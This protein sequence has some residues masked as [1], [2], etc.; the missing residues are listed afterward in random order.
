MPALTGHSITPEG[1]GSYVFL[2]YDNR[3]EHAILMLGKN[4]ESLHELLRA[5]GLFVE[6]WRNSY[7]SVNGTPN[8]YHLGYKSKVWGFEAP[9]TIILEPLTIPI[10]ANANTL[11]ALN[12]L[13]PGLRAIGE[14][15]NTTTPNKFHFKIV[16]A[17]TGSLNWDPI[18]GYA[19]VANPINVEPFI[20]QYVAEFALQTRTLTIRYVPRD[21]SKNFP[22]TTG[23]L[24][25][26]ITT[27]TINSVGNTDLTFLHFDVEFPKG[28]TAFDVAD[29][30]ASFAVD[31]IS[32]P[33]FINQVPSPGTL[34]SIAPL[35]GN[36]SSNSLPDLSTYPP[37]TF[38][39]PWPSTNFVAPSKKSQP[40]IVGM[41]K[42]RGT[43]KGAF[44]GRVTID[45]VWPD[46]SHPFIKKIPKNDG[47]PG[48][49]VSEPVPPL[50]A[51]LTATAYTSGGVTLVG[52]FTVSG[53][54]VLGFLPGTTTQSPVSGYEVSEALLK[55][56]SPPNTNRMYALDQLQMAMD[57][58]ETLKEEAPEI[59]PILEATR[60]LK[61]KL[62]NVKR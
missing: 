60:A 33:N 32:N 29:A 34:F 36:L 58:F 6:A 9:I 48:S 42:E 56:Y 50:C 59:L 17:L 61:A 62:D 23:R 54:Q 41:G 11:I 2:D 16:N 27:I 47:V 55:A 18:P 1:L 52:P 7:N 37:V 12:T 57:N 30:R 3:F 13:Y 22:V 8:H 21:G 45:S 14:K 10:P 31:F 4:W 25:K 39:N 53:N 20:L 5:P 28:F 49:M 15:W 40:S 26:G 44:R 43:R 35:R 46:P 38:Q 24:Q 51:L 19:G